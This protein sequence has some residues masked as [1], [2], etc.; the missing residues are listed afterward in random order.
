MRHLFSPFTICAVIA[1]I[2]L[3]CGLCVRKNRN[4]HAILMT[5]GVSLDFLIVISLQIAKHVMNTVSH[6]HLSSILVGHVLTSSIA[7][8]LYIPSLLLGYQIFRHPETSVEFKPGYLKM[9]YTA[10]AF[11]TVGLILMFM[12]FYI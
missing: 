4:L 3:A 7:I 6:Q 8:V 5:A 11:R 12:M 2:L 9:I 10:F 1:Y